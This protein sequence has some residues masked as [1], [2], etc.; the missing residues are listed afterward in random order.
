MK[1]YGH[2]LSG[3]AHRVQTML[4]ILGVE[5]ENIIVDLPGRAHK[6][7]SFL[8]MNPLG[9][10]PVLVDG[11]LTLRDSTAI[12]IY[13]ARKF[14]TT[15]RWL[16]TDAA[17]SAKVQEWLSIAVHEVSQGP[18]VVRAMKLFGMPGDLDDVKAKSDA[19]FADLFEPH[20]TDRDWLVGDQATIADIACYGYI[21]RITDGDYSLDA[22][23]AMTAWL[24][25]IE[26]LDN[27]VP[28]VVAADFFA[29]LK[30]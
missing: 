17:G 24:A 6:E 18:F 3:N 27:F 11:D 26:A 23:P 20:L 8:A 22:Y 12:L 4:S 10:I 19:L 2:P 15:N 1:L 30:T 9:Q 25:R 5:H 16:P 13:L 28:M 21:A 14:D 29:A 7:P